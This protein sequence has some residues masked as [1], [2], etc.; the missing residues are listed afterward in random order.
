MD[1]TI[2][3]TAE[4]LPDGEVQARRAINNG[5]N[6]KG[7]Y[8]PRTGKAYIYLP[9]TDSPED[10]VKTILHEV[11]A[12][13]GLRGLLGKEGFDRLCDEVWDMM[14]AGQRRRFMAYVTRKRKMTETEFLAAVADGNKRRDAADEYIAHRAESLDTEKLATESNGRHADSPCYGRHTRHGIYGFRRLCLTN[15]YDTY[16]CTAIR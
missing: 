11:V 9:N 7:W 16:P 2:I 10:A 14:D 6:V 1:V 12:H 3:R 4:E 8:N 5:K 13:K 15:F